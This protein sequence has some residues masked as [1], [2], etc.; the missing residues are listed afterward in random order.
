MSDLKKRGPM[1]DKHPTDIVNISGEIFEIRGRRVMLDSRVAEAFETE[2][3]RIN[4]AVSRN[5]EKFNDDHC[6]RLTKEEH[7][8]LR[9]LVATS[10]T[11]QEG[12]SRGGARYAPNVFTLKGVVRLATI[13]ETDVALRATDIIVDT[14]MIV[15]EQL[16]E[17]KTSIAIPEP[18]RY[19][20]SPED[21][22]EVKQ[23]RKKLSKA[24]NALLDAVI[25][26]ETGATV[27]SEGHKLGVKAL[28]NIQERLRTKGLEN[29]KLEADTSLVL[30]EAEKVLAEARRTHTEADTNDIENLERKI[31]LVKKLIQISKE[32]E[33]VEFIELMDT[34]DRPA[35]Q[36][37]IS[38]Q[39]SYPMLEMRK[40][41]EIEDD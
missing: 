12:T 4:E 1:T 14:F 11:G 8:A 37:A 13:L 35:A 2:T 17:G 39:T 36:K 25:D 40:T 19:R 10:N 41:R 15:Q 16:S 22:A 33:P 6:F 34:F 27:R 29:A 24:L 30:A 9:S 32:L 26:A 7:A 38:H 31:N 20:A 18:S 21:Y 5:P 3:K 23:F 28:Q